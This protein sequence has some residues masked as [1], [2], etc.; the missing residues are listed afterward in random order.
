MNSDQFGSLDSICGS[1]TIIKRYC[2]RVAI[3]FNLCMFC[4]VQNK[5]NNQIRNSRFE[6]KIHKLPVDH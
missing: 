1:P 3:T 5:E 4:K 2:A 6:A